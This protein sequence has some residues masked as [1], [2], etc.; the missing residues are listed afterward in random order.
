MAFPPPDC[1]CRMK[2]IQMAMSR[3]VG[4]QEMSTVMYHACSS[5]G[6]AAILTP[7]SLSSGTMPASLGTY[8]LKLFPL[9]NF[10]EMFSPWMLTSTTWPCSTAAM[11]SLKMTPSWEFFGW[12]KR[13]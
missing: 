9:R 11:K 7:F 10:P 12:L 2:K 1:I 8:V 5:A 4:N 13:L 6:L 3:M